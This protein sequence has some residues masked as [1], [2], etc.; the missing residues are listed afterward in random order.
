MCRLVKQTDR[1]ILGSGVCLLESTV[2]CAQDNGGEVCTDTPPDG[3]DWN[4]DSTNGYTDFSHREVESQQFWMEFWAEY[5]ILWERHF[6]IGFWA[7]YGFWQV[8]CTPVPNLEQ[9]GDGLDSGETK[10]QQVGSDSWRQS[11]D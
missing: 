5:E 3:N 9:H 10:T 4:D 6:W 1:K 8:V 2:T 7:K 11:L